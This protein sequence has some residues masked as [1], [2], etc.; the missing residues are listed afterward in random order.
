MT[1]ASSLVHVWSTSVHIRNELLTHF[2]EIDGELVTE[3]LHQVSV[4]VERRGDRG[5]AQASLY[6]LRM[7]ALLDEEG[8]TRMPQVVEAIQGLVTLL[9][10]CA[11]TLAQI[12]VEPG[13]D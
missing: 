2:V 4:P 3:L 7:G 12:R 5:V 6:L 10:A 11:R 9:A 13:A 1:S 8:G